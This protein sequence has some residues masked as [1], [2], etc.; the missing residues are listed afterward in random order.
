M[1][2]LYVAISSPNEA[3]NIVHET[4]KIL[5]TGGFNR[6]KWNS[7]SQQVL[8]LLNPDIRFNPKTSLTQCQKVLG[9]P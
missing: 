4:R 3:T 6:T 5:A 1:D 2:D 8:D 7:K 9:L